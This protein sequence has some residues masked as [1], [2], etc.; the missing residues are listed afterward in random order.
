LGV[1]DSFFTPTREARGTSSSLSS[2][3]IMGAMASA[4]ARDRCGKPRRQG[5]LS[6]SDEKARRGDLT[7]RRQSAL[8]VDHQRLAPSKVIKT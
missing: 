6:D 3:S 8:L 7:Q 5:R 1:E 2:S 4:V